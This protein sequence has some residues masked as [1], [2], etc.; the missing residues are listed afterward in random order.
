[1]VRFEQIEEM[2]GGFDLVVRKSFLLPHLHP[3]SPFFQLVPI[4]VSTQYLTNLL[5][6]PSTP[7]TAVQ[8]IKELCP[9]P[10][11]SMSQGSWS[12][13][14]MGIGDIEYT[15]AQNGKHVAKGLERIIFSRTRVRLLPPLLN[16]I[17]KRR[18]GRC[19]SEGTPTFVRAMWKVR[20][21]AGLSFI[22]N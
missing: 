22:L 4:E 17:S 15:F 13:G 11:Q 18:L 19:G 21:Y 10:I 3:N 20:G 8:L 7:P 6:T 12:S 14:D 1:M 16:I 2:L 9:Y 5:P